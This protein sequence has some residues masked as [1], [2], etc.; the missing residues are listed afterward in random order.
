MD[1]GAVKIT[2]SAAV[3]PD[4]AQSGKLFVWQ[5]KTLFLTLQR[6]KAASEQKALN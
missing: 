5:K 4:E 6:P 1:G 3:Y 2:L